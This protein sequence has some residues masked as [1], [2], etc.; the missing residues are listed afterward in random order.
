MENLEIINKKYKE[1]VKG[2]TQDFFTGLNAKWY[3][4]I[5][6]LPLDL[7][8]VYLI[9]ILQDQVFNGGLDQYFVNGYG[10]F[11]PET[12]ECLRYIKANNK[13]DILQKAFSLINS[14]NYS[15]D[16]FR[17]LLISNKIEKLFNDDDLQKKLSKLDAEFDNNNENLYDLL[18]QHIEADED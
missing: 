15:P 5:V 12:I 11:A 2:M 14:N 17:S 9:V 10:Q 13:A 3:D 1:A 6:N 4:Y 16:I 7:R 8:L 18:T